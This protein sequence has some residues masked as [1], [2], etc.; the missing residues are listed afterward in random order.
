VE[1]LRLILTDPRFPEIQLAL[2]A[3]HGFD[4]GAELDAAIRHHEGG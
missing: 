2:L 3:L 1:S 4:L